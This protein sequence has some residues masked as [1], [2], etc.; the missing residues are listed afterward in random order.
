MSVGR[1]EVRRIAELARLRFEEEEIERL[2]DEMNRILEHAEELR[3]L[4]SR[5][6]DGD[7]R[8]GEHDSSEIATS[9]GTR[10][11]EA[12]RPDA[13]QRGADALAPEWKDGFF[14]V[15]PP[16]GVQRTEPDG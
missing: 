7:G 6:D 11:E 9:S 2:T 13:L 4:A 8:D 10:D 5:V 15:P 1:D 12:E 3:G 16:P 14:V